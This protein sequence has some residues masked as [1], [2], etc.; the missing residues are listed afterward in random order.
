MRS[1]A[2]LAAQV[3][4]HPF[5]R[6]AP[7]QVVDAV[8]ADATPVHFAVNDF[9]LTEGG[10][11]N[12]LFLITSGKVS[13]ELHWAGRGPVAIETVGPGGVVGWSWLFPPY[14]WY[15]DARAIEPVDAIRIDAATLR[16]NAE[17]D[18]VLG[19]VLMSRIAKILL[20]RLQATRLRAF[21][22]Y[23]PPNA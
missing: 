8:A 10:D 18:P 22:L 6:G 1:A 12:A 14:R 23:G 19:Q 16:D 20:E 21:D 4:A 15:F 7:A 5:W 2:D 17:R 9:L 11:A 13:I 3:A